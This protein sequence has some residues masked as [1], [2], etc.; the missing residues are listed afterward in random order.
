M[1]FVS[2]IWNLSTSREI[3]EAWRVH[4]LYSHSYIIDLGMGVLGTVLHHDCDDGSQSKCEMSERFKRT[5]AAYRR[6][7]GEPPAT[8]WTEP[9]W[10]GY[11]WSESLTAQLANAISATP[12]I[13]PSERIPVQHQS[14]WQAIKTFQF[15]GPNAEYPFTLRLAEES[16][17][18]DL[19]CTLM[20]IEEYRK[21]LFLAVVANFSVVP[22]PAVDEVWHLH[23]CCT[24]LYWGKMYEI[25][26]RKVHHAPSDGTDEDREL[27][28]DG[29]QR[30]LEAY[31]RFFGTP[32][33]LMWRSN[34]S[35]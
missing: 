21:F 13:Q 32:P 34:S 27:L 2:L 7:F 11:S 4:L 28:S 5:L 31:E 12:T 24:E 20:A 1:D 16:F 33:E 18:C 9:H 35:S 14:L 15:D 19:E 3:E 30:T 17:G 6:V 8:I 22:S 10:L 29:Y 25:C 26:G 23:L